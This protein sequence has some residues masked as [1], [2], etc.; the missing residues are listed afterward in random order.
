MT[1]RVTAT[2]VKQILD[3]DLT[4]PVIEV[5]INAANLTVTDALGSSTVLSS[6]QLKEI[7]RWLTAHLIASTRD[8]QIQED[9][10]GKSK[11]VYQGRTAMGLDATFYGQQV[12]ILDTSGVLVGSA[13]K[14]KATVY[15]ATSFD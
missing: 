6:D 14:R 3:T 9:T 2:E 11:V 7:E 15:A 4:D 10:I 13:G 1:V 8:Q 12:K 5:F